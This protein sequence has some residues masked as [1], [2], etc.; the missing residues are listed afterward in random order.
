M[1]K[2]IAI[3]KGFALCFVILVRVWTADWTLERLFFSFIVPKSISF[4]LMGE[5]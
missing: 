5:V 1:A 4:E 3:L 2:D